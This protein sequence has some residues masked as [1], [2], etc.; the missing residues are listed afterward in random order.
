MIGM[1]LESADYTNGCSISWK[2][3]RCHGN[4]SS[5]IRIVYLKTRGEVNYERN[6]KSDTARV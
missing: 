6:A 1:V 4:V 2:I 3:S 5:I